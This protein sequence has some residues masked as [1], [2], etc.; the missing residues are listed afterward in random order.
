MTVYPSRTISVAIDRDRDEVYDFASIPENFT[1]W[2]AGLGRRFGRS[3]D[4]WIAEG[5]DGQPIRIRFSPANDFGV[6]DHV[7]TGAAGETCNAMRVIANG[8]G[9]DVLFTVHQPPSMSE[10]LFADDIAA[11]TRDLDALKRLLER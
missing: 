6:I 2:A 3:G 11:V 4:E 7:V 8:T 5:P 10:Q 9:A 1:R